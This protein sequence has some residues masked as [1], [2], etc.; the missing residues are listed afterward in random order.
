M[1]AFRPPGTGNRSELADLSEHAGTGSNPGRSTAGPQRHSPASR[2]LPPTDGLGRSGGTAGFSCAATRCVHVRRNGCCGR[3]RVRAPRRRRL[4]LVA[5]I[6]ALLPALLSAAPPSPRPSEQRAVEFLQRGEYEACRAECIRALERNLYGEDWPLLKARAEL[7][8]GRYDRAHATIEAGLKRYSWSIRLRR[9]GV[10]T[11]RYTGRDELAAKYRDE[12]LELAERYTWRYTDSENL[13]V[14]GWTALESGADAAEVLEQYFQRAQKSYPKS[15]VGFVAAA[16]L[17]LR[18]SDGE[19]ASEIVTGARRE[20]PDDTDLLYLQARIAAHNPS[21]FH[22]AADAVLRRNPRHVGILRLLAEDAIDRERYDTAREHL[23]RAMAVDPRDPETWTLLAVLAELHND[24]RGATV[25]RDRALNAWPANPQ[26]DHLIGRKLSQ[27]YRFAEGAAAQRRALQRDP[28]FVPARIQLAQDLLRLGEEDLGWKLA[29]EA[30]QQ[31]QYDLTSFNLLQLRDRIRQFT[32]FGDAHFLIRMPRREAAVYGQDVL[33]LL[34]RA[35]SVLTTRYGV[36]PDEPVIV[37]IFSDPNDFAVRTF[38]LPRAS[39]YLGVCFGRVITAN[40]PLSQRDAPANWHSVLWHEYAH[41]VTLQAT[42]NRIPR[43]FSEGISVYEERQANPCWGMRMNAA[44]RRRILRD[45]VPPIAE[46]S[47]LFLTARSGEDVAFAYYASSLAVEFLIRRYGL[48][49]VRAVLSDLRDGLPIDVALDRQTAPLKELDADFATFARSRASR[50]APQADWSIPDLAALLNDD[51]DALLAWLQRH[52]DNVAALRAAAQ[53]A[54]QNGDAATA[55]TCAERLIRLIPDDTESPDNGY[56]LLARALRLAGDDD[57]ERAVLER[58]AQ[59]GAAG[60]E[61]LQ[62]LLNDVLPQLELAARQRLGDASAL[63]P[64]GLRATS[65][66][67]RL[68]ADRLRQIDPM[69][70][71]VHRSTAAAA[72]LLGDHRT[73]ARALQS[74][75][76]LDPP[77]P[78]EVHYAL[79]CLLRDR[80]RAAARRHVLLALEHAPRFRAALRLLTQIHDKGPRDPAQ[81]SRAESTRR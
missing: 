44:H 79:A 39:G 69:L 19:L 17:A 47:S 81:G 78:A 5:S 76:H 2:K 13:V 9:L 75:V 51:G 64:E 68:W 58:W 27:K 63:P 42:A 1:L 80:D 60:V 74:L 23:Q 24:P 55:R 21:Q 65:R 31:D 7:A 38:G 77:D 57:G 25:C 50:F 66:K 46:L 16:E 59:R 8:T 49:S 4:I 35:R 62:R 36:Q 28:K 14:L 3:D 30:F 61:P 37:E 48:R 73:A 29:E 33:E 18:K 10:T 53:Q 71:L 32:T 6:A 70:P 40:S 34:N 72:L 67:A 22:A 45:G 56:R 41:V 20:F 43:W 54:L 52:P 26:V 15:P 12:I 11:S